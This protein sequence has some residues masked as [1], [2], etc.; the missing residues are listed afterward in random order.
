MSDA[1]D[2]LMQI[3][4][5]RAQEILLAQI[6]ALARLGKKLLVFCKKLLTWS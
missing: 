1:K 3:K 2:M 6:K 4:D 5:K